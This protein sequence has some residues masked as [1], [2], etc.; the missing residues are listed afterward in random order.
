MKYR[1]ILREVGKRMGDPDLIKLKGL[2]S[3]CFIDSMCRMLSTAESEFFNEEIPDLIEEIEKGLELQNQQDV[4]NLTSLLPDGEIVRLMDIYQPPTL[5]FASAITLKEINQG[6]F[7]RM[8]LEVSFRPTSDEVFWFR[9]GNDIYFIAGQ[10][11]EEQ[12]DLAV[13]FQ[14]LKNPDPDDWSGEIDLLGDLNYSRNFIYRVIGRTVENIS[15]LPAF[16]GQSEPEGA[17]T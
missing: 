4:V 10:L 15:S 2:V 12:Y 8:H 13:I 16:A 1:D 5:Q 7:K 6:E 9:R 14:F 17:Y 3:Q 11:A